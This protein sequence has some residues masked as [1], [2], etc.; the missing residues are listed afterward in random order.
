MAN[1]TAFMIGRAVG[2]VARALPGIVR[3]IAG[4]GGAGLVA[5]GAWLVY[6]PAGFITGGVLLLAGAWLSARAEGGN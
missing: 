5:Y 1:R 4:L 3:D 6:A 2:A